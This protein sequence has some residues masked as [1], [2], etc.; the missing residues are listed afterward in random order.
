MCLICDFSRPE[1]D[2]G[3]I[4]LTFPALTLWK[5]LW[6]AISSSGDSSTLA[7]SSEGFPTGILL[8]T[9]VRLVLVYEGGSEA[10]CG[11]EAVGVT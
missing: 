3:T 2:L 5:I 4:D 8:K 9:Y 6:K 10:A 1:V 7:C 11:M